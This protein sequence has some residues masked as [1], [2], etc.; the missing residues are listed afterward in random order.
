[1]QTQCQE[2]KS[3]NLREANVA[4]FTTQHLKKQKNKDSMNSRDQN[5]DLWLQ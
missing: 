2:G 5:G 3:N 1:M 4:M